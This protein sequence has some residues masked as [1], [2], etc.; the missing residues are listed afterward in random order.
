MNSYI[1]NKKYNTIG[2]MINNNC[3]LQC[4]YCSV[5]SILNTNIKSPDP[6]KY[7]EF[8][9]YL[10]SKGKKINYF[11][12]GGEP[13]QSPE[14]IKRFLENTSDEV[15]IG[16]NFTIDPIDIINIK[17]DIL[18]YVS[19]HYTVLNKEQMNKLIK[20]LVKY[21]KHITSV[22]I[23]LP[24]ELQELPKELNIFVKIMNINNIEVQ[25]YP[26]WTTNEDFIEKIKTHKSFKFKSNVSVI[27]DGK[28]SDGNDLYKIENTTKGM[29]CYTNNEIFF[30]IYGN[31]F[32]CGCQYK[33]TRGNINDDFDTLIQDYII[34]PFEYCPGNMVFTS[35][36]SI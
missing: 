14:K 12:S 2:F 6:L 28:T 22:R 32:P 24:Y 21:K 5:K 3:S 8:G 17:K 35:K 10:K 29:K 33:T 11:I 16:T 9:E 25:F 23:N 20:R 19:L 18:F 36:V 15:V 1:I 4:D 30:D 7:I 26:I 31:T 27:I 13:L 34:C